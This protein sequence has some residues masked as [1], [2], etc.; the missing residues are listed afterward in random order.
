M[1]SPLDTAREMLTRRTVTVLQEHAIH[2]RSALPPFRL[3]QVGQRIV[4][5]LVAYATSNDEGEARSLGTALG[6]QGLALRSLLALSRA[7]VREV[8]TQPE[9]AA[10]DAATLSDYTTLLIEAIAVNEQQEVI[11]Q[12]QEI[13]R[14]LEQTVQEQTVQEGRLR[15]VIQELSSPI[16]P[17]Y[18]GVLVLPLVGSIDSRR[19]QD[20]TEQLLTAIAE[21]QAEIVILDITGVP[22]IDTGVADRLLLTARAVRLLG[23][24]VL[25]VGISS[26]IAQTIVQLGVA[27]EGI[28]TLA[29]LQ[30]GVE[31]ALRQQ[32]LGIVAL[33]TG[34]GL[35]PR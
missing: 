25:L 8:L 14:A 22:V 30:S 32:G 35:V 3:P 28:V 13:E 24:Q 33:P 5:G 20:I 2:N 11:T 12:R 16:I 26:E 19:S 4:A 9:A 6:R 15:L 31:Y 27:L 21:Q 7:L 10:I 34:N 1:T 23:A 29:N 18:S 17:I